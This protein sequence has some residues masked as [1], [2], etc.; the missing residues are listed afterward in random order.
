VNGI[1]NVQ[2]VFEGSSRVGQF[3][4]DDQFVVENRE[5]I[6]A[7]LGLC[8]ILDVRPDDSGRGRLFTCAS[9]LFEPLN[10]GDEIPEYRIEATHGSTNFPQDDHEARALAAGDGFKFVAIRRVIVRVPAIEMSHFAK[11]P[12]K[13]TRPH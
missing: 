9:D 8:V 5:L 7:L 6:G 12:V 10:E 3:R 11:M 4:V 2:L 1:V 13:M